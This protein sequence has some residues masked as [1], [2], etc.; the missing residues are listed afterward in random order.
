M[1]TARRK[2]LEVAKVYDSNLQN[3]LDVE[4]IGIIER[5]LFGRLRE[6]Y[7]GDFIVIKADLLEEERKELIAHA[8][9]HHFLHAGNHYG[10]SSGT[11]SWD[12]LQERQADVFAA[13]LLTPKVNNLSVQEI[14]HTFAVT[15]KFASFRLKLF[16][17]YKQ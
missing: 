7:F 3:I 1:N 17:A 10:V 16:E 11:Y 13:Y 6:L 2:A 4:G 12:K 15:E 9:G 14:V 5:P 8:L